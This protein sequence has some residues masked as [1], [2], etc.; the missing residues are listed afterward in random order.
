MQII[1]V[2]QTSTQL[3]RDLL[4]SHS[5]KNS[6][7]WKTKEVCHLCVNP[8]AVI[9]AQSRPQ[10]RYNSNLPIPDTNRHIGDASNGVD[11]RF[12]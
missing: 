4:S 2:N 9:D 5:T 6:K 11:Y 12:K 10:I 1:Y 3:F 7:I 8:I